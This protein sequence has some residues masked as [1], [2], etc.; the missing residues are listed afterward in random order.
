MYMSMKFY[1]L[2][3]VQLSCDFGKVVPS[4]TTQGKVCRGAFMI[5]VPQRNHRI[6]QDVF[7][8]T[9]KYIQRK[10]KNKKKSNNSV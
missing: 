10:I 9:I 1:L 7:L 8:C 2:N 6:I 4:G 3:W 5:G